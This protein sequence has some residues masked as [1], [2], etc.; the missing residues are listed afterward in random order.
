MNAELILFNMKTL[1][2]QVEQGQ[3]VR[4]CESMLNLSCLLIDE[5]PKEP[6]E[7]REVRKLYGSYAGAASTLYK[8]FEALK[9]NYSPSED[10]KDMAQR[11]EALQQ[12]LKACEEEARCVRD[13]NKDLLDQEAALEKEKVELE[14]LKK[15]VAEL[16]TLKNVELQKLREEIADLKQEQVALQQA[17]EQAREEKAQWQATLKENIALINQLPESV[18]AEHIDKI[19]LQMK[20]RAQQIIQACED[21]E[22]L[23]AVGQL[24]VLQDSELDTFRDKIKR[25]QKSLNRLDENCV[26]VQIHREKW[27][28]LQAESAAAAESGDGGMND[29]ETA[30]RKI[31]ERA[32]QTILACEETE[33]MLCDILQTMEDALARRE[34]SAL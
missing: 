2:A 27:E 20:E 31:R 22:K 10:I 5:A 12:D 6:L 23:E 3:T 26:E 1:K 16:N 11:I 4:A 15:H 17:C 14:E 28:A 32:H 34:V 33:K 18:A 30:I 21:A 7:V 29:V 13:Q 19:I 9:A 8:L 24:L 25:L